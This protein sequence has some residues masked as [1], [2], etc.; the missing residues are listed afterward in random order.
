MRL[1]LLRFRLGQSA[2]W[3]TLTTTLVVNPW[4]NFDPISVVKMTALTTFAFMSLGMLVYGRNKLLE[5]VDRKLLFC[6]S[7]F[8]AC[9]FSTLLF[10]K[11]PLPQQIWGIFGRNTG[12]LSYFSLAIIF[13]TATIINQIS[14]YNRT[15]TFLIATAV[16][17]TLYCIIQI[18][19]KDPIGWSMKQTFGTLGNINFLSAFMGLV[20]VAC[21]ALA[22]DSKITVFKRCLLLILAL[23]DLYIVKTTGSIQGIM[24]SAA[25]VSLIG[26]YW[27]GKFHKNKG[28][29][30][31]YVSLALIAAI[32]GGLGLA[33][34]GPLSRILFQESNVLRTDYWH[35]GWQMT[36][37]HPL[38]GVGMDSYGDWYREARGLISTLRGSP[39]RTANTAHNIFLDISSNGGLPLLIAY[40]CLLFFALRA[41]MRMLKRQ[42]RNYD[43]TFIALSSV[44]F[45]YQ[46]QALVSINQLGVGVWGWLYSGAVVGYEKMNSD[47]SSQ[48]KGRNS[49]EAKTQFKGKPLPTL[50]SISAITGAAVGLLLAFP[51][52]NADSRFF[53]SLRSGNVQKLVD[54]SDLPGITAFH[55]GRI[56]ERSMSVSD[57]NSARLIDEQ[58]ISKFPRDYFGWAVRYDLGNSSPEEKAEA[59]HV[60]HLL[61]PFNPTLPKG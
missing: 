10:S 29:R 36:T 60:L 37:D 56:I 48:P 6:L 47:S 34:K 23:V 61:D 22:I 57:L 24:M 3:A 43:A 1:D 15:V 55:L 25:G 19:G 59:A 5:N 8:I 31:S 7:A 45:A 21:I 39:D 44:W 32:V 27:L 52:L 35:A 33:N 30:I 17:M 51:A 14:F 46:I 26:F 49:K 58:L 28:L 41:I 50:A 18:L 38:F 12:I 20:I 42:N 54:I 40:L 13:L 9:M 16:P 4:G 53:N 2:L 11:A